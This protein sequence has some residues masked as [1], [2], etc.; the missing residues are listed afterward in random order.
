MR[1]LV[2]LLPLDEPAALPL[3]NAPLAG[4]V[5]R[6]VWLAAPDYAEFLH[7]EGYEA[8]RAAVGSEP[9]GAARTAVG[10][11]PGGVARPENKRFKF[12]VFSRLEQRG[13]RIHEGRQWLRPRPVEWQIASPLDELMELLVEGLMA[14]GVISIGDRRGGARLAVSEILEIPAP[15]FTDR[16]RF[17]TLSP[18]F[19]SVDD[20]RADGSRR[21]HH[22]RADDSR[23]A[24]AIAANLR[25][26]YR[27]LT[28]GEAGDEALD[29]KFIGEPKPQL[30]QYKGTHHH[31]Y[32]GTFEVGGS[33][34]LL[35]V[36]WECG[37]GEA[38]SK[39]FGM[40]E[41]L[42]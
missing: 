24:E 33:A 11:E 4:V 12:F 5:Y 13:K 34:E 36:G 9:G 7:E 19:V 37:F 17:R 15:S 31:C 16:M 25:G 22:L 10:S 21:K 27:A 20:T 6:A 8:A 18:L 1:I 29:F 42:S 3:D 30:A 35:R 28:G 39:G 2:R 32:L 14:Q 38:N 26:K 23:F 40:A 41:S